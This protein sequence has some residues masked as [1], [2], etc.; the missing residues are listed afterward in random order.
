[1]SLTKKDLVESLY[2]N[3]GFSKTKSATL[4]ESLLVTIKNNLMSGEEVL[5]T[6]FGKFYVNGKNERRGRNPATGDDLLLKARR[7]IAFRCSGVLRDKINGK[8]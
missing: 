6:G 3:C 5:I 2:N 1:M 4:T 8:G 7:V